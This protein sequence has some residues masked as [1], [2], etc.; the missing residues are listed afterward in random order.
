MS[1]MAGQAARVAVERC[2]SSRDTI[3]RKSLLISNRSLPAVA[4][5]LTIH[6]SPITYHFLFP[7]SLCDNA[8]VAAPG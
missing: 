8:G 2:G 6:F 5:P 3:N 4:G 7:N 1:D